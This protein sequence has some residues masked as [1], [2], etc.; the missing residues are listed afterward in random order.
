MHLY[1][2]ANCIQAYMDHKFILLKKRQVIIKHGSR[3]F[4]H[5]SNAKEIC[6][7]V[8]LTSFGIDI[9]VY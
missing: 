3:M 4:S 5:F 8:V 1:E 7:T 2:T 9:T 6:Y